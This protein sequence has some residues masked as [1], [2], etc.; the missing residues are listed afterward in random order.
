MLLFKEIKNSI[1][2]VKTAGNI[3]VKLCTFEE[4]KLLWKEHL[5]EQVMETKVMPNF[6]NVEF[7]IEPLKLEWKSLVKA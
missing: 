2:S 3:M 1:W 7:K 4:K 5:F 6:F